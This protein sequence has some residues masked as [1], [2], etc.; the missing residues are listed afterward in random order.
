MKKW[1]LFIAAGV[2]VVGCTGGNG[3]G[4][5]T[6]GAGGTTTG[7]TGTPP[8]SVPAVAMDTTATDVRIVFLSGQGRRS[9]GSQYVKFNNIRF[10]NA[11]T[12]RI[13]TVFNGSLDGT[14]IKLDGFSVNKYS[15]AQEGAAAGSLLYANLSMTIWKMYEEGLSGNL[16]ERFSGGFDVPVI[17]VQMPLVP[18]RQLSVQMFL[19][20]AALWWDAGTGI[21]WDQAAFDAD[22]GIN[23][24]NPSLRARFSDMVAFDVSNIGVKPSMNSGPDAEK[25]LVSGDGFGLARGAGTVGSFDLFSPNF[26]ESGVITNPVTL[27]GPPGSSAPGTYTVLEPDPSVIPPTVVNIAALQGAWRNYAETI[28]NVG[29]QALIIFPTTNPTQVHT[30]VM[31][32][33]NGA[34]ITDLWY[35]RAVLGN[36]SNPGALELWS[37]DQI[38][39]ATENNK[40]IGTLTNVTF[41]GG[42]VKDGDFTITT[43]P[44]GFPFTGSGTF[45]IYR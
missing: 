6:G 14:N 25:F 45:A 43:T 39:N 8:R 37:V 3:I 16:I 18:G 35:G 44:G 12:D 23:G 15:F 36:G 20:D 5:T 9:P 40:A 42:V 32:K 21:N 31:V 7:T 27:G 38:D 26:I 17:P 33:R 22:N 30:A 10:H 4:T 29:T 28:S 24:G 11:L 41:V 19:N 34:V 13:P 1:L 2:I